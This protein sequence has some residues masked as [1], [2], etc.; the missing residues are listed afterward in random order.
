[1]SDP[2][3]IFERDLLRRRRERAAAT[4]ADFDFLNREVAE[5]LIDRLRDIRRNFPAVLDLGSHDGTLGRLLGPEFGVERVVSTDLAE[6]FARR[7]PPPALAVDEEALPFADASFD[8]VFSCLSLHW[9]NDLPGAL[10]QARRSLRPDG[11]F[12]GAMLGGET[13]IELREALMAAEMAAAGG[14]SPRVSPFAEVRDAGA[15]LQRAGFALP[16]ADADTV[17][18][19]YENAW[20]LMRDLRGMGETNVVAERH[21][22]PTRRDVLFRAAEI[23]QQRHA[24]ADGRIPA[25]F[26]VLYLTGWAPAPGQPKPLAPGSAEASFATLV[27]RD[28]G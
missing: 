3:I 9:V 13:L 22:Q 18:V 5:R 7:A 16:V 15:L 4:F 25:T 6:G 23:Y 8:A 11:L 26:Q 27:G 28:D 20:G 14:A 17:T 10:I 1:M 12:L 24:G 21:R 2:G 19:T